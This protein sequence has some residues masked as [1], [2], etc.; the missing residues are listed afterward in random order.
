[1]VSLAI[2]VATALATTAPKVGDMAPDFEAKDTDGNVISLS[3]LVQQ[4]PVLLAFFPK[5]FTPN[6][7]KQLTGY[8]EDYSLLKEKSAHVIAISADT[9]ETQ[10]RF[11]TALGAPFIF[12]P[13]PASRIIDLYGITNDAKDPGNAA[14]VIDKERRVMRVDLG[15]RAVETEKAIT[16]CN[17]SG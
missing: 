13:D 1:M 6:C 3:T 9:A 12:I 8:I 11:K 7:T 15:S 16:A 17:I 14:F 2:W 4:G 5:A 10:K